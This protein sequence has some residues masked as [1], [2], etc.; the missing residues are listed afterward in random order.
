M[1]SWNAYMSGEYPKR[2]SL[3]AAMAGAFREYINESPVPET[4]I[5]K[6]FGKPDQY[7]VT[8]E[9]VSKPGQLAATNRIVLVAYLFDY[10][11]AANKW[12]ATA[13]LEEGKVQDIALND[14]A[15][16]ER[17]GFKAYMEDSAVSSEGGENGGR[18]AKR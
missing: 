8:N 1:T 11:G 16:N 5:F 17:S 2:A 12:S 4:D 18:P 13:I 10:T 14:A 9:V 7:F 15:L 6:Y 3:F